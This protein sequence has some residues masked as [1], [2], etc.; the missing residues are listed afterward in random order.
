MAGAHRFAS[1]CPVLNA[2]QSAFDYIP[3]NVS[4]LLTYVL[5]CRESESVARSGD[6]QT[7]V[8]RPEQWY[9]LKSKYLEEAAAALQLITRDKIVYRK[10]LK[11]CAN[12]AYEEILLFQVLA[13]HHS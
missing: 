7:Q 12:K 6:S 4:A 11:S 9:Q 5:S 2:F 3:F 1:P 13:K 10:H 8:T